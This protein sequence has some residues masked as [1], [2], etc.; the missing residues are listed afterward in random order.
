MKKFIPFVLG[1]ILLSGSAFAA[2]GVFGGYIDLS[3]N[4]TAQ[5][6]KLENPDDNTTPPFGNV[7]FGLFDPSLGQTFVLKGGE[8]DTFKNG[9]SNVTGAFLNYRIY[10]TGSPSGAF[11]NLNL[12]FNSD[13][14]G[15]N[16]KWQTI[17]ATTNLLAGLPNGNYTLE[18]YVNSTTSGDGDQFLNNGGANYKATFSVVPEP[19]SLT[20]LGGPALLGAWFFVRRRRA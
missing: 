10:P 2:T 16:Q 3:I 13:L 17:A 5:F 7:N 12:P 11:S 4:G 8:A 9:A 1:F 6:Y 20:L 18:V 19:S 15:G 14:G